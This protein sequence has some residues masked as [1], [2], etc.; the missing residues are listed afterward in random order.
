MH[1]EQ[2]G[3]NA[4]GCWEAAQKADGELSEQIWT[5]G[6]ARWVDEDI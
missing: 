5:Q 6:G 4:T 2:F 3:I 1:S